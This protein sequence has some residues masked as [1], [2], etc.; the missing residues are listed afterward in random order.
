MYVTVSFPLTLCLS[1]AFVSV[2]PILLFNYEKR[3]L[4]QSLSCHNSLFSICK[5]SLNVAMGFRIYKCH[6]FL[7]TTHFNFCTYWLMKY[8]VRSPHLGLF[9]ILLTIYSAFY[10]SISLSFTKF[11]KK[12]RYFCV[13]NQHGFICISYVTIL[14]PPVEIS[15]KTSTSLR[16][17]LLECLYMSGEKTYLSYDIYNYC[18]LVYFLF[19]PLYTFFSVYTEIC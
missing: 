3:I 13:C 15:C 16:I 4:E 11:S 10:S 5:S 8:A 19:S 1:F 14:F 18:V 17:V 6:I 12:S 9:L 2:D 7:L